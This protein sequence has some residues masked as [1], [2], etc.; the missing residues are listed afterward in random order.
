VLAAPEESSL[1]LKGMGW[2]ENTPTQRQEATRLGRRGP[3]PKAIQLIPRP[4]FQF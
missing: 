3:C 1:L 4:D 2:S